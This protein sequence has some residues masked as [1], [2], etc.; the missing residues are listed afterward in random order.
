M[1]AP[2]RA[3]DQ[4]RQEAVLALS[5]QF[6]E[7]RLDRDEFDRRQSRAQE[8]VYLHDLDPLFADLPG[9]AA[10]TTAAA[11]VAPVRGRRPH[12]AAIA[13][14]G[15]LS[16][17]STAALVAVAVVAVAGGHVLW[18][19]VP[20]LAFMLARRARRRAYAYAMVRS[21]A[22]APGPSWDGDW[23]HHGH[24]PHHGRR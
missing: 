12:P 2:M 16:F 22:P 17:A 4:D 15:L 11:A 14:F 3:S 10:P 1:A 8:A 21:G 9:R 19:L 24:G 18:L 5:D 23:R 20:L 13:A 6:A 7:G